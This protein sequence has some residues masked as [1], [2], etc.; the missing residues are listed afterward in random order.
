MNEAFNEFNVWY[1]ALQE[2]WR[3]LFALFLIMSGIAGL[4]YGSSGVRIFAAIYLAV[5]VLIR[6]KGGLGRAAS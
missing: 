6:M 3:M 2:P 1:D 4:I 5:L